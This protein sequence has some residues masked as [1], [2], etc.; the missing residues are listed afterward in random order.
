MHGM[1]HTRT[2]S[3]QNPPPHHAAIKNE[4][5]ADVVRVG[6]FM[7]THLEPYDGVFNFTLMDAIIDAAE[8]QGL[9]VLLGTPSATMPAWL[10]AAH[11]ADVLQK[12]PDAGEGYEGAIPSFG[13][14]RQY[15][16]NSKTYISYAVR[17]AAR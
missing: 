7:W 6:E 5:G 11:G 8:A 10:H 12:G 2:R 16:F 4:L 17:I 15:S 3:Q 14:R 13:G 1:W 9:K